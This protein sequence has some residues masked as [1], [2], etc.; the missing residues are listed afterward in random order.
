[1]VDF[2]PLLPD[3]SFPDEVFPDA[4]FE[5]RGF[6]SIAIAV[7]I[8]VRLVMHA[9]GCVVGRAVN[10]TCSDIVGVGVPI[11]RRRIVDVEIKFYCWR[12]WRLRS[13]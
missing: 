3:E 9:L 8:V 6:T 11:V 2:P 7:A 4:G 10:H 12:R 13:D 1:M 5:S